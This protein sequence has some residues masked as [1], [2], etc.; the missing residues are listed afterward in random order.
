M[1]QSPYRPLRVVLGFLA[2][3]FAIAGA[4]LILSTK[5]L[6]LRMFVRPPESEISTLLLAAVKEVGGIVLMVSVMLFLAL[7]DPERNVAIIDGMIVGLFSRPN[8]APVSVHAGRAEP[9]S[10]FFNL[11]ALTSTSGAGRSALLSAAATGALETRRAFLKTPTGGR[12]VV[13]PD[14]VR[15]RPSL[16]QRKR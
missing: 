10:G 12:D 9:L 6:I 1:S 16:R 7:R 2:L 3:V 15:L 13:R 11:A 5:P 4:F 8:A 14:T